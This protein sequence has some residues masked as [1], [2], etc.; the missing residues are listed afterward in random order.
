MDLADTSS[1]S[2]PMSG[3]LSL[4]FQA[5]GDFG[6][7]SGIEDSAHLQSSSSQSTANI[8]LSAPSVETSRDNLA[9]QLNQQKE[10]RY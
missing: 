9:E 5:L 7:D 10:V 1:E 8:S 4:S 6:N 2:L 3:V